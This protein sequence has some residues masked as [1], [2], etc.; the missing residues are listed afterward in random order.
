MS[1]SNKAAGVFGRFN[2][3]DMSFLTNF[4]ALL[5][6]LLGFV[7]PIWGPQ[8]KAIGS[9]ALSGAITN[10]LAIYMLFE[11]IPGLYGSGIIPLK[12]E[13]FK[14]GIRRL[15]M[16]EFFTQENLER[17]LGNHAARAIEADVIIN[18]IDREILFEKLMGAV[19]NSPFG[20]MLAMFGGMDAV[21]KNLRPAFEQK[22]EEAIWEIVGSP[23][24]GE[25]LHKVLAK[26]FSAPGLM[27]KI[28]QVVQARLE[29]LTPQ[30]V[31]DIIQ[32]MIRSHLG[33]LVVW[34]GVFGAILGLAA[35]FL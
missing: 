4:L 17:F 27:D 24:F 18:A 28:E 30:M 23:K 14:S 16:K 31:K 33:W 7:S 1:F 25:I 21:K 20:P 22:I 12:F 11:R 8:L 6:F 13:E 15:I 9:Y 10:W 35:S 26:D 29:E 19:Q 2:W 32:D 3:L 5:C 34:G